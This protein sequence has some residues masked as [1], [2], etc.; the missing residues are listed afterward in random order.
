MG[1]LSQL[2]MSCYDSN[3]FHTDLAQHIHIRRENLWK[4]RAIC[5]RLLE[6]IILVFTV[7]INNRK[8]VLR[9]AMHHPGSTVTFHYQMIDLILAENIIF[10]KKS[11]AG[12][13]SSYDSKGYAI[14][15]TWYSCQ[16][17]IGIAKFKK[18]V[19]FSFRK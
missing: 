17:H 2:Y 11:L 9:T 3:V 15:F 8:P 16:G 1:N 10:N 12:S 5:T 6:K 19:K 4:K 13:M 18:K 14:H 7:K